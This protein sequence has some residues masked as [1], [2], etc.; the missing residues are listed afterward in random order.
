MARAPK[1]PPGVG[2]NGGLPDHGDIRTAAAMEMIYEQKEKDLRHEKKLAR[3]RL[4]E[5]KGL[6]QDDMKFLKGLRDKS[7]TEMIEIFKRQWHTVGAFYPEAHEQMDLFSKKSEAPVRAAYYTMGL[8]QGL[9]G[10]DLEIPPM[11]V[12]D[13][14][15]QVIAGHNEGRDRHAAAQAGILG[16]AL[17]NAA[18][19]HV[20]DGKTGAPILDKT[21]AD[22]AK[23]QAAA[24]DDDPL[25][26]AGE[27]Y[28]TV[29]QANAARKRLEQQAGGAPAASDAPLPWADFPEDNTAWSDEQKDVFCRWF[30]AQPVDGAPLV[31]NHPGAQAEFKRLRDASKPVEPAAP[32]A[33]PPPPPAVEAAAA[34]KRVVPI[35]DYQEWDEDWL[36]WTGPQAME[37]RRYFESKPVDFVP[38]ITH[39]GAVAMWRE[40]VAERDNRASGGGDDGE[41]DAAA[42]Q[43]QQADLPDPAETEAA[44]RK[45]A[46]SGF[47]PPKGR[48]RAKA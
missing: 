10:K 13:D 8:L 12:G 36:K 25:V 44:A 34:P 26:V 2:H 30:D 6:L 14:Q 23:D 19:G 1:K 21:A 41:W 5:G 27:R 28:P 29:R 20:T 47:V 42:P 32:P 11:V 33:S 3:S 7:A 40:L 18:A 15:Q 43:R 35:P 22:F 45:L 37:F 39:E 16:Q 17:E 38:A 24:G 9:Q 48:S 46:D 31:I 4:V